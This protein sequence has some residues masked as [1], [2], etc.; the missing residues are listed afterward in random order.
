MF[1]KLNKSPPVCLQNRA[2]ARLPGPGARPP[3]GPGPGLL[4]RP[5]THLYSPQAKQLPLRVPVW[6]SGPPPRP[7]LPDLQPPPSSRLLRSPPPGLRLPPT[8]GSGTP[9]PG[10]RACARPPLSNPNPLRLER[11]AREAGL[12]WPG[13]AAPLW[14]EQPGRLQGGKRLQL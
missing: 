14:R 6:R 12:P 1:A 11:G 7:R 5:C 3:S 10:P 8:V 13:S 2:P 9:A 4:L